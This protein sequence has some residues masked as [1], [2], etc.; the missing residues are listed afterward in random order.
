MNIHPTAS[1][2]PSSHNA[3]G[4]SYEPYNSQIVSSG[5]AAHAAVSSAGMTQQ[6]PQSS[7]YASYSNLRNDEYRDYNPMNSNESGS[8]GGYNAHLY[9]RGMGQLHHYQQQQQQQQKQHYNSQSVSNGNNHQTDRTNIIDNA[10]SALQHFNYTAPN[11][12][13][14]TAGDRGATV[15]LGKNSTGAPSSSP[16]VA[17]SNNASS[18]LQHFNYM[19]QNTIDSA[20]GG[21]GGG[22]TSNVVNN[23]PSLSN[24]N[25]HNGGTVTAST[26]ASQ[27]NNDNNAR[28][29]SDRNNALPSHIANDNNTTTRNQLLSNY[30]KATSTSHSNYIKNTAWLKM[31]ATQRS[32]FMQA[33]KGTGTSPQGVL[34]TWM[35]QNDNAA[36]AMAKQAAA[37]TLSDS[38]ET[39]KN[40]AVPSS[41]IS[42][43]ISTMASVTKPRV[44]NGT[45][46]AKTPGRHSVKKPSTTTTTATATPANTKPSKSP[47]S[48]VHS[49]KNRIEIPAEFPPRHAYRATA[50]YSLLRTLSKELRLSPFTLQ[51]FLSALML[52]IPSRLL[53]EIHVRVMRVLFADIGMGSYARHGQGEGPMFLKRI[54]R[55]NKSESIGKGGD[56]DV[57]K[58]GSDNI[59]EEFVRAR[60]CDNLFYMDNLTWPLFYED[61]AVA[62]EDKFLNDLDDNEEFIDLRSIAMM[63]DDPYP[64]SVTSAHEPRMHVNK[65]A[66]PSYPGQGWIDRCPV[67]PFGRRNPTT[68]R[69]VCCPFHVHAAMSKARQQ[70]T[71]A[72]KTAPLPKKRKR[73]NKTKARKQYASDGSSS[74][75]GND[76]DSDEDFVSTSNRSKA[77]VKRGRPRKYPKVDP[78]T[79]ASRVNNFT[80]PQSSSQM[81]VFTGMPQAPMPPPMSQPGYVMPRPH[82]QLVPILVPPIPPHPSDLNATV[83]SKDTEDTIARYF[84]EGDLFKAAVNSTCPQFDESTNNDNDEITDPIKDA[85]KDHIEDLNHMAPIKQL[86]RGIPYHHLSIEMKLIMIEFLLD[87]L[88]DVGDISKELTLRRELAEPHHY[89]YGEVPQKSEFDELVNADECLVC[90]LE[91]DL[92]CCDACPASFHKICIGMTPY[93]KLPDGK[94]WCPECRVP[95]ASRMGPIQAENRPLIGWFTLNELREESSSHES[96]IQSQVHGGMQLIGQPLLGFPQ[97][98]TNI[99]NQDAN[100]SKWIPV[101]DVEFLVTCGNVF[102]RHRQSHKRFD[103]LNPFPAESLG[104]KEGQSHPLTRDPVQPL[105]PAEVIELL[106]LIGPD[107]CLKLPWRRLI[108]N[109]TKAFLGDKVIAPVNSPLQDLIQHQQEARRYLTNYSDSGNP[110]EFDNKYRKAPPIPKVKEQLGQFVL[111]SVLPDMFAVTP[112]VASQFGVKLWNNLSLNSVMAKN[113]VDIALLQDVSQC[114]RDQ[115]F[116]LGKVLFDSS[117]LDHRWGT[118]DSWKSMI[119]QAKSFSRLSGLLV[120]LVDACSPRAFQREWYSIRDNENL[121]ETARLSNNNNYSSIPEGWTSENELRLRKWQRCSRGQSFVNLLCFIFSDGSILILIIL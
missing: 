4:L 91:G 69:F 121:E 43:S 70:Y 45:D 20:R 97:P 3:Y 32:S 8:V 78:N 51:S 28:L 21:G 10:S 83:V 16:V 64:T 92:L 109:A 72:S 63:P 71:V 47:K 34:M 107:K 115:L 103:P 74:D 1:S 75:S 57:D 62:T 27:S 44:T 49:N 111:P 22:D 67:G 113:T 88:L 68:G 36:V 23:G 80:I 90:G 84:L 59:V 5:G 55:G 117:L 37:A 6:Q 56:D 38:R 98:L 96:M 52:P 82:I 86:R 79:P 95:D 24:V 93:A 60:S 11:N 29:S 46:I 77:T 33:L 42:P 14:N 61:Y 65:A 116:K 73:S 17:S 108:F 50:A 58:A 9:G 105:R 85:E 102:A 104:L 31:N 15:S 118:L 25:I 100:L 41:K 53:G 2:Y 87:E 101:D 30:A 76:S 54:V 7:Y 89:L 81:P 114:V 66:I 18:A 106:K 120:R 99:N 94:W 119:R 35:N 112:K 40:A 110:L 13:S 12:Y 39:S 48:L 19:I 26:N